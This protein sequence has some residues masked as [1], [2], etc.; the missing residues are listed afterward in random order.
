MSTPSSSPAIE[1]LRALPAPTWAERPADW[2]DYVA[3]AGVGPADV[4]G[5]IALAT[6]PA[7]EGGEDAWGATVHAWRALAQLRAEEAL[8]P[9]VALMAKHADEEDDW[10]TGDLPLAFVAFG[11]AAVPVLER[12][13]LAPDQPTGGSHLIAETLSLIGQHDPSTR[14]ACIAALVARLERY[15]EN[16]A[17]TNGMLVAAL[18]DLKAVEAEPTLAM[19]FLEERVD[20][21]IAGDWEDVQ[22][23]LGLLT[24][25]DAMQAK[26]RRFEQEGAEVEGMRRS[27]APGAAPGPADPKKDAAKKKAKRKLAAASRKKNRKR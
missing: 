11:R 20:P 12:A 13:L 17:E 8:A 25:H 4:P 9:L 14:F 2:P 22:M 24:F 3:A 21:S 27:L 26:E 7:P 10:L 19:A 18:V 16:A 5:L 6:G 23:S 1:R 15:L